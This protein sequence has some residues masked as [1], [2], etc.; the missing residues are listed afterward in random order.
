MNDHNVRRILSGDPAPSVQISVHPTTAEGYLRL[1][2]LIQCEDP[3]IRKG[4]R[5][6]L[7]QKLVDAEREGVLRRARV[8]TAIQL[9][10]DRLRSQL[11]AASSQWKDDEDADNPNPALE[12]FRKYGYQWY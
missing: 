6:I 10:E 9:A 4:I 1:E 8:W 12:E 11:R 5:A 2:P 3:I 7:A